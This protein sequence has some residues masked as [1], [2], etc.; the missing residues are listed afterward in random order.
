MSSEESRE[1]YDDYVERQLRVG[2]N[3]RHRSILGFLLRF[4][5]Q[6]EH[7]VLEIGCGVGTLTGLIDGALGRGGQLLGVDLSPRSVAA[8]RARLGGRERVRLEVGDVLELPLEGPFDA[9]VLPD[10]LEHIP[11]ER[12]PALFRTVAALLAPAGFVL[13]HYPNPHYLAWRREHRPDLLQQVDQPVWADALTAA[14]YPA[15]LTLEYLE[16]YSIWVREG[17]YQ[18]ALFRPRPAE[19]SFRERPDR[20]GAVTRIR[21]RV[22]D[23]AR[24]LPGGSGRGAEEG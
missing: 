2:V 9:V 15:G 6:P 18:V 1:F 19:P 4:G 5:L 10:V 11:R 13:A 7:R 20:P 17:D 14:A 8:A 21:A 16:T 24:R 23:L 3:E 12:H 22:R